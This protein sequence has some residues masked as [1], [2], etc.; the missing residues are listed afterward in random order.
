MEKSREQTENEIMESAKKIFIKKGF[1]GATMRD[2]AKEADI[3]LAMLNYYFRSKDNLFDKIFEKS[4]DLIFAKIFIILS[5]EKPLLERL[6]RV[7]ETHLNVI[8]ENPSIPSFIFSEIALNPER[9][10]EKLKNQD[11]VQ[12]FISKIQ[13]E[14][15]IESK[16]G[17]IKEFRIEEFILNLISLNVFPFIAKP[18]FQGLFKVSDEEYRTMQLERLPITIKMILDQ[19]KP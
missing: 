14:I 5:E 11:K 13:S 1:K 4:F 12:Y 17:I 10:S 16:T 19:L 15:Q 2:I 3:N 6:E 9:I 8:M 7:I 18:V